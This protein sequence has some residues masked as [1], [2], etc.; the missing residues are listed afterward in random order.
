MKLHKIC[1]GILFFFYLA[2]FVS[3]NQGPSAEIFKDIKTRIEEAYYTDNKTELEAQL[4]RASALVNDKEFEWYA[5]YY[6]A[7][8]HNHLSMLTLE[9]DPDQSRKHVDA[10]F[11]NVDKAKEI[12]ETAELYVLCISIMG[13]KITLGSSLMRMTRGLETLRYMDKARELD[14]DMP[15]VVFEHALTE[16]HTPVKF[17]GGVDKAKALL[18]KNLKILET[19]EHQDPLFIDW[20]LRED[21]LAWLAYFEAETG[22]IYEAT[23]YFN[24]A[25]ALRPDHSFLNSVVEKKLNEKKNELLRSQ[26][27]GEEDHG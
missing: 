22:N 14:P 9:S 16:Y 25:A 4:K 11:E 23:E 3:A 19:Y 5:Y 1:Y 21:N 6:M 10:A 20:H 26:Q 12:N 27:E 13:K 17:G 18:K 8:C 24:E 15:G 7:F 2:S